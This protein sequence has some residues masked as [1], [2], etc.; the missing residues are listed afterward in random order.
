MA[1]ESNLRNR[2]A[3][4]DTVSPEEK[5]QPTNVKLEFADVTKSFGTAENR[6]V[7][8]QDI[9][10][11]IE[12]G[13]FVSI[14]GESGCGKTTLLRIAAGLIPAASGDVVMDGTPVTRPR[15][16][17]GFVFQQPVL[18][19]WRTVI[20]NILLPVELF[21]LELRE[22]RPK[23][24]ELLEMMGLTEFENHYPIQLS[25]AC[26]SASPSRGP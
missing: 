25:G 15:R 16:D 6:L 8:L 4:P 2:S 5:E 14:I 20:E 3:S 12:N 19:E 9:N 13:E 21:R 7:V 23:V 1:V 11:A 18:L 26:N 10:L 24:L 17:I 22:Y